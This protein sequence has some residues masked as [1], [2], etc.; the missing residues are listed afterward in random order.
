MEGVKAQPEAHIAA[1][2]DKPLAVVVDAI[3]FDTLVGGSDKR[4]EVDIACKEEIDSQGY[5]KIG[6]KF[7]RC[8]LRFGLKVGFL[9]KVLGRDVENRGEVILF[10]AI[11]ESD[12]CKQLVGLCM[13][14]AEVPLDGS[15]NLCTKICCHNQPKRNRPDGY[16]TLCEERMLGQYLVM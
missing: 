15:F 5:L 11:F 7:E 10:T 12:S 14:I 1:N 8:F 16:H 9:L 6:R 4:H 3:Q 2:V 13:C